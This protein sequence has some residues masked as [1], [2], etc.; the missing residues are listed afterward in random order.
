ML[1][2]EP[3]KPF[4]VVGETPFAPGAPGASRPRV[5]TVFL[6]TP[7][8]VTRSSLHAMQR[9]SWIDTLNE[10]RVACGEG[11]LSDAD[12]EA[13][14]THS[15][16]LLFDDEHVRRDRETDGEVGHIWRLGTTVLLLTTTGRKS[17]DPRTVPLIYTPAGGSYAVIASRGGAPRH[18]SWYLNLAAQ[19]LVTVQVLGEV[20]PA[21]ARTAEGDEREGIWAKAREQWPEYD[22]YATRT[23]R[24]IPVV[25]LER[26]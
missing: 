14:W 19:P 2:T 23:D 11:P 8:L 3:N 12:V 6:R 13:E 24:R 18:P 16:D 17:G 26:V 10:Q 4:T 25:V 9:L 20:F 7:G 15:V 5:G 22:V 1:Q 21:R